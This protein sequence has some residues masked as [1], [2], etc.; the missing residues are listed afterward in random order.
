MQDHEHKPISSYIGKERGLIIAG[1]L[2]H[3]LRFAE[4]F[5]T[6]VT[7]Q[8]L[9]DVMVSTIR[10][11]KAIGLFFHDETNRLVVRITMNDRNGCGRMYM[12]SCPNDF[13]YPEMSPRDGLKPFDWHEEHLSLAVTKAVEFF[14][15][16]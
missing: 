12:G 15:Q 11:E 5:G 6:E 16:A 2:A 4:A 1:G 3:A 13:G 14:K 9:Q 8:G 10:G 7:R